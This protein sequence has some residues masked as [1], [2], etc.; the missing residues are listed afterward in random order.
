M[1]DKLCSF[2]FHENCHEKHHEKALD[3]DGHLHKQDESRHSVYALKP[4]D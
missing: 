2:F 4:S 3:I 1:S